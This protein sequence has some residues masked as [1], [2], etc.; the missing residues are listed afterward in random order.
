MKKTCIFLLLAG[1]SVF[2]FAGD[3]VTKSGSVYQNYAIMGAAPDGIK[4]FY[5]NGN[6][7][8]VVVLPVSEF[9][10]ELSETVSISRQEYWSGSHFLLL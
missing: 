6:G 10:E 2:S 5:N 8:R 9:P 1:L 4:V 7:D 3:L